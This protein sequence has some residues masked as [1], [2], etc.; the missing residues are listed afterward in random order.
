MLHGLKDKMQTLCFNELKYINKYITNM[1]MREDIL[2]TPKSWYGG[3]ISSSIHINW[4]FSLSKLTIVS[5][6]IEI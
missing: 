4:S 5:S 3:K 1:L 6:V 2:N